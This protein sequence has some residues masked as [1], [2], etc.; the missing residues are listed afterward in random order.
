MELEKQVASFKLSK[1]LKELGVKQDSLF[2][3]STEFK[4]FNG[5]PTIQLMSGKFGLTV[6]HNIDWRVYD[7]KKRETYSA[8]TVAELGEMLPDN[9]V[10]SGMDSGKW[11]CIYGRREN[12]EDMPDSEWE[13][14]EKYEFGYIVITDKTEAN[15]RAKMLIYL[16]ENDFVNLKELEL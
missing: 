10:S 16:I 14:D 1:K 4:K 8:F 9:L 12:G 11:D 2:E 5:E 13:N 3:W 6:H 7:F 15:V